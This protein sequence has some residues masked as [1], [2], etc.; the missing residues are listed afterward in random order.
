MSGG[1]GTGDVVAG[2]GWF[3]V[4]VQHSAVSDQRQCRPSQ[5]QLVSCARSLPEGLSD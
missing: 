5:P 3:V 2:G 4:S 1:A